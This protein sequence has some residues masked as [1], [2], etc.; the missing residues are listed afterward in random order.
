MI[1][2]P[3]AT[4]RRAF[5]AAI[6]S[7]T[8]ELAALRQQVLDDADVVAQRQRQKRL[9]TTVGS[10]CKIFTQACSRIRRQDPVR[11][12]LLL[13]RVD[14]IAKALRSECFVD[15]DDVNVDELVVDVWAPWCQKHRVDA[16]KLP[17]GLRDGVRN[18]VLKQQLSLAP[19]W[20]R[21]AAALPCRWGTG[22]MAARRL[23]LCR[24]HRAAPAGCRRSR[25]TRPR[26]HRRQ[27][28]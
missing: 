3:I 17:A 11:A 2:D 5:L 27:R 16:A 24:Q 10:R 21:A 6:D 14:D 7:E 4:N 18:V 8:A 13:G 12:P 22:C 19:D 26:E 25:R 9:D 20:E 1:T 28:R 15:G 23:D